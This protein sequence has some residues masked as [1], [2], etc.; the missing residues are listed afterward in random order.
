MKVL[1][2]TQ[3]YPTPD[4]DVSLAYVRTRNVFYKSQGAY[5]DIINFNTKTEYRM[6]DLNVYPL[7][8][9]HKEYSSFYDLLICHAP[10]LRSHYKFLKKYGNLFPK[11][12]FFFHGH[13]VLKKNKVYSKPYYYVKKNAFQ[14][15]LRDI[16]DDIK[17]TM[18]KKYFKNNHTSCHL[19]FV[20]NWMRDEFYKWV[21]ISPSV[22][23]GHEHIT[24][25]SVGEVFEKNNFLLETP[26]K[27]DFVTIRSVLDGSKYAVDIVNNLALNNPNYKFLLIGKGE[28]FNYYKKAPNLIW[29]DKRI[30]HQ[31]MLKYLNESSCALMPT[32]TDAQGVMM[33]EMA[34]F[35]IPVITSDI[36]VCHEVFD[37]LETVRFIDN[38][39]EGKESIA[40]IYESIRGLSKKHTRYYFTKVT[41]EEFKILRSIQKEQN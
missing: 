20:S 15:I 23:K 10:N 38:K 3:A 30:N 25:N 6:D 37:N 4:G 21:K 18:W 24:Y 13:E 19:I 2:L 34:A 9:F 14:N 41:M 32:R 1:V 5:V 31:E 33:C 17:L 16:Y 22:L 27:Y 26:K 40:S 35:G 7:K 39:N 12:V 29:I 36:P 8:W 11:K 28:F